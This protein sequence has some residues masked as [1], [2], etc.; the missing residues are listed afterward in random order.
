MA[1][2]ARKAL[3]DRRDGAQDADD[4]VQ[5]AML[6]FWNAMDH[7]SPPEF[8]DR[9][10]LWRFLGVIT[11]RKARRIARHASAKKRGD[12]LTRSESQV[13]A[14]G[15]SE[16]AF[17][18]DQML[19]EISPPDFDLFCE[20]MLL[21]LD[22]LPRQIAMLRLNGHSSAEIAERLECS[23]RSVQRSLKA[24]RER[25]TELGDVD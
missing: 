25:W 1:G 18:L 23:E 16:D 7:A 9:D 17:R 10:D 13:A 12:R 5:C 2:L 11:V 24:I 4:V 3:G 14:T 22:E 20:E 6:S 15:D 19:A 21:A 8:R